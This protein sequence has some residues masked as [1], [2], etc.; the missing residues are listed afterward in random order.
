MTAVKP[1]VLKNGEIEV[2]QAGDTLNVPVSN[3]TTIVLTNDNAGTLPPGTPVYASSPGGCDKARAN[4]A[5]TKNVIGLVVASVLTGAPATVQLDGVLTLTTAEWDAVTGLTGG[6]TEDTF[7]NL[8][9]ATAGELIDTPAGSGYHA[10]VGIGL[11]TT[12]MKIEV[13]PTIKL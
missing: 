5:G 4:A 8:D 6:L 11:S 2:F 13:Q 10:P 1:L 9:T 3:P 12:D 7:Y